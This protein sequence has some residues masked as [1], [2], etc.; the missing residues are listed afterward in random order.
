MVDSFGRGRIE[1]LGII[2]GA[3]TACGLFAITSDLSR[4]AEGTCTIVRLR[5]LLFL[6][7]GC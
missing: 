3:A 7:T 6:L 1:T 5:L 4:A 2:T